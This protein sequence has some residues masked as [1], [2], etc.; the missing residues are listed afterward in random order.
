MKRGKARQGAVEYMLRDV[1]CGG[2]RGWMDDVG[3]EEVQAERH[4]IARRDCAA[5]E[6]AELLP[7]PPR[8]DPPTLTLGWANLTGGT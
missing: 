6:R 5:A 8:R 1:D 7:S 4:G 3:D 2:R